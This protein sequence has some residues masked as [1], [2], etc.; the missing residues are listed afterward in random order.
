MAT[1]E[2]PEDVR[3]TVVYVSASDILHLKS[4][5]SGMKNYREMTLGEAEGAG[6]SRRC[7]KCFAKPLE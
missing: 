1:P 5:C 7:K 4:N 2:T 6:L 3:D